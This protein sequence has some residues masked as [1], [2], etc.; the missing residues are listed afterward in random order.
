[1]LSCGVRELSVSP[2]ALARI[3]QT[4]DTLSRGDSRG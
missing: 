2:S 1:L 4:I 3:K